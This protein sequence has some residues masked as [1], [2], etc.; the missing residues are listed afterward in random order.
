[1]SKTIMIDPKLMDEDHYDDHMVEE[2]AETLLKAD[3]IR[4]DKR[5]MEKINSH[6]D[7]KDKKIKSLRDLKD[8]ANNY[9]D[10]EAD[11]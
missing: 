4:K 8:M 10:K 2:S 1:M 3:E 7:N 11:D 6:W 9:S 5:L